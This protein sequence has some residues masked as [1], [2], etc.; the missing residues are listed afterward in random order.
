V[1]TATPEAWNETI[2]PGGSI[3][4]GFCADK[5]DLP[6]EKG[7]EFSLIPGNRNEKRHF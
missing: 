2:Q 7:G 5:T 3:T 4:F 1:Y 6:P